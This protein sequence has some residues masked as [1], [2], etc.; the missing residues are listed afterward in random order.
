MKTNQTKA[1]ASPDKA[2]RATTVTLNASTSRRQTFNDREYVV[3][4]SIALVE[5]V[6]N[7]ELEPASEFGRHAAAWDGRPVC[8]HHPEV[9]GVP[10]SANSLSVMSANVGF[11]ANSR[12]DGSKLKVDTYIDVLKCEEVGGETLEALRSVER[13]DEMDISVGHF[14][15][16]ELSSGTYNGEAYSAIRRNHRPDHLAL[17]PGGVGACSWLAGCGIG[18][19]NQKE[20]GDVKVNSKQRQSKL[21]HNARFTANAVG[22]G[23]LFAALEDAVA[24]SVG[25]YWG[26]IIREVFPDEMQVVYQL[27]D[28]S[29]GYNGDT[30]RHAYTLDEA[31]MSATLTGDAEPVVRRTTYEPLPATNSEDC[32][33]K[34]D[35]MK[36]NERVSKLIKNSERFNEEDRG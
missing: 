12:L 5:C 4:P 3:V 2:A 14:C 36:K 11:L 26:F 17:L 21:S 6:A 19:T 9:N 18:R 1:R 35:D 22:V 30:L 15:D 16:L 31:T 20:D 24:E 10:I 33:C 34:G 7:G 25:N 13:G 32:D 8:V 28:D 23:E 27:E 29:Y